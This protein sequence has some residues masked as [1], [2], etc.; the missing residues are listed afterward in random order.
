MDQIRTY[1]E[2][3][4]PLSDDDWDFFSSKLTRVVIPKKAFLL[5]AGSVENHLSFIEQ[6]IVRHYIPKVE[7]DITYAF[8]FAGE[9]VS[10]Y[11]S[12][13][14]RAPSISN[15]ETLTECVFWQVKHDDLQ[16]IYQQTN[17]GNIIGRKASEM[18][19][20]EKAKRELSLLN[21]TAEERYLNL[22]KEQPQLI[23]FIPQK[24]LA[25]YIGITPQA[26][27]RIRKRIS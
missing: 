10:G 19:F 21:D 3:I 20:I 22:F 2:K 14:T 27:S 11:E 13:L 1:F 12:F 25:S 26:L 24:Y 7:N 15:I 23:R 6:G 4:T 5:R 8:S 17:A 18:L 16:A 9:F